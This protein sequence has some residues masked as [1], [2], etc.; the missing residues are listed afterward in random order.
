MKKIIYYIAFLSASAF[1]C[2]SASTPNPNHVPKE[3]NWVAHLDFQ[4]ILRSKIGSDLLAEAQ[5]DPQ[6]TQKLNGMKAVF[7]LDLEKLG[8]ATAYGS[9]KKNEGVVIAK[10]G[11]NSVQIEGFAALNENVSVQKR[12]GKTLYSFKKGAL[13]SLGPDSIIASTSKKLLVPGLDVL[14]GKNPGQKNNQ[15]IS[16]LSAMME[17]P[18]AIITIQ[19]PKVL[20]ILREGQPVSAPEAAIMKKADLV[21][22][23]VSEEGPT[24]RMAMVMQAENEETAEHLENVLRGGSSLLALGAGIDIDRNLDEILPQI[25]TSVS[26]EKRIVGLQLEVD[27]AFLLKKIREEMEKKNGSQQ[28][29]KVE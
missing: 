3:A 11:I 16:H 18:M 12:G 22:F 9:G 6:F 28:E 21:G 10:G 4:S 20:A 2:L 7:G 1:P 8:T 17:K 26:R 29:N 25:K 15:M 24:M 13:C 5:K 23:A 19:L 14:S 27:S